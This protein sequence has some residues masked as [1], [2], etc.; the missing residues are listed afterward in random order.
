MKWDH[1]GIKSADIEKSMYFYCDLLGLQ[2]QEELDIFGKRFFFVGNDTV[3][4]EIEAGSPGDRR[5]DPRA[6]TG[7]YHL[8]F[9]VEDVS[10]LVERLKSKG[11]PIAL[12]PVSTRPD[13]LVAFVEDPD[14][15]FI[16]LIQLLG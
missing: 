13:R 6:Q 12:E 14:G 1:V 7:L 16:Q 2:K 15:A 4:I 9:T 11:V 8:A 10:G 5:I 3:S